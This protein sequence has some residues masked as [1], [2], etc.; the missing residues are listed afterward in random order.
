MRWQPGE[1]DVGQEKKMGGWDGDPAPPYRTVSGA[2]LAVLEGQRRALGTQRT[3]A[4]KTRCFGKGYG[5]RWD[6]VSAGHAQNSHRRPPA[7]LT[8]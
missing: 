2:L 8:L 7:L 5:T 1:G 6:R 4:L 3:R